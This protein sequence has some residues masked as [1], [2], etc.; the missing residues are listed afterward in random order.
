MPP[1]PK[2]P[3]DEYNALSQ[4]MRMLRGQIIALL[5]LANINILNLVAP[6]DPIKCMITR[7]QVLSLM[8]QLQGEL[9][10]PEETIHDDPKSIEEFRA[11]YMPDPSPYGHPN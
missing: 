4:E 1:D 7:T 3:L 9:N 6:N 11:R 5:K 10:F 2:S 8:L